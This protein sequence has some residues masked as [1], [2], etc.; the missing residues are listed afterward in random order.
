MLEKKDTRQSAGQTKK[1]FQGTGRRKKA[2][3]RVRIYENGK[4]NFVVNKKEPKEFFKFFEYQQEA[5]SPLDLTKKKNKLDISVQVSGGGLRG[6]AEA[7]RHGV[8]RAL[9]EMDAELK[10]VLRKNGYMTRDPRSKERKK[11]GLKRARKAPQWRK[12]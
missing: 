9:V 10:P 1:Y 7:I 3:A 4:G 12:R 2:T 11:P 5:L 8:A 6:Q